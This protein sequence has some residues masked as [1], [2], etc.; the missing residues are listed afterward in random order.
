MRRRLVLDT[1]LADHEG[2]LLAACTELV[3]ELD[4]RDDLTG[5]YWGS[6]HFSSDPN[7]IFPTGDHF[8]VIRLEVDVC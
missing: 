3:R 2:D 6:A 7:S 8:T 4:A 1:R 5:V